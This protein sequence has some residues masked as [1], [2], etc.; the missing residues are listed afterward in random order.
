MSRVRH[1]LT[2]AAEFRSDIRAFMS[3]RNILEVSP[4]L[5]D[6]YAVTDPALQSIAVEING[7]AWF[8]QTSPEFA[9]KR[10]LSLGSGDIYSLSKVFRSDEFGRWHNPE[11]TMLEWYRCG[12]DHHDLMTEVEQLVRC[13]WP[14]APAIER[15]SHNELFGDILGL[16]SLSAS[17]AQL[18]EA[19][20]SLGY[21]GAFESDKA[22][23]LDLLWVLAI[24]PSVRDRAFFVY[25]FP[26][27][28][29]A[30]ARTSFVS[31]VPRAHRFELVIN[32][33]ELA[34]GFWELTDPVE[35]ARRFSEDN[36]KRRAMG[37]SEVQAD[38][39]LL[40]ALKR[41]LPE[42]AGVALGVDRL[43]A[44]ASGFS[45]LAELAPFAD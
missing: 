1:L 36:A 14:D 44:L 15:V 10:L 3:E 18:I 11:F 4:P 22:S 16:N 17:E 33:L 29:A 34:N 45:S 2:R 12:F 23:L 31:G 39:R 5:A 13:C 38:P 27:E 43:L 42:C 41:G 8:L 25:D 19:A 35:Q 21:S 26:I 37:L 28:Q 6:R 20:R 40:E 32:G 30:L 7:A 9:L 24:E